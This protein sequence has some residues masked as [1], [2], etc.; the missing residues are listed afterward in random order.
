MQKDLDRI[1]CCPNG[2]VELKVI[3]P[4][5]QIF[6]WE[7]PPSGQ[8]GSFDTSQVEANKHPMTPLIRTEEVGHLPYRARVRYTYG[9][10]PIP[11]I[12]T[13]LITCTPFTQIRMRYTNVWYG[14]FDE[15]ATFF[16][17]PANLSR[18]F[19]GTFT[20]SFYNKD[21]LVS[22]AGAPRIDGIFWL[23]K[24]EVIELFYQNPKD[25]HILC[26]EKSCLF[27]I[28][29]KTGYPV[30]QKR[31]TEIESKSDYRNLCPKVLPKECFYDNENEDTTKYFL[32][33]SDVLE[34]DI[35]NVVT[36]TIKE[37]CLAVYK[38]EDNNRYGLEIVK[39]VKTTTIV[40]SPQGTGEM[41]TEFTTETTEESTIK[42]FWAPNGCPYPNYS[43][44]CQ[45]TE[46]CPPN[47]VYKCKREDGKTC[48]YDCDGN[49]ITVI[50]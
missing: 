47:T 21:G 9:D 36:R 22:G 5:A 7:H 33:Y 19:E 30:Y 31:F 18:T 49:I 26:S 16:E 43:L 34:G 41:P 28:Q 2:V 44:L 29:D 35:L 37:E 45:D 12:T 15:D 46:E 4:T 40:Y 48:C 39:I 14:V 50:G 27:Q 38:L 42:T 23:D 10:S 24:I 1:T 11:F 20:I 8:S 6:Y 25:S 3:I 13:S 17:R 32:E